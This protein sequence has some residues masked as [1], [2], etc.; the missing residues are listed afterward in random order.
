MDKLNTLIKLSDGN[1]MPRIG[2]GTFQ[3]NYDYTILEQQVEAAVKIAIDLGYRSIDTAALYN[4]EK[5]IGKAV[6][7]KIAEG[8]IKRDEMFITTKLWNTNHRR[9]LVVPALRKSLENLGLDYVDMYLIHWP[10]AVRP[11][12]DPWPRDEQGNVAFEDDVTDYTETWKGMIECKEKG[13]TR[14]IG[15]SNFTEKQIQRVLDLGLERP[16]NMQIEVNPYFL[17]ESLVE[18]C[19]REGIQITCFSP[20]H[21]PSRTWSKPDDPFVATDETLISIGQKFNKSPMQVGLRFLLQ[22]GLAVLPKSNSKEHQ[23]D[24][25]SIFD[26]ELS[27]E[28]MELIKNNCGKFNYRVLR[29]EMLKESKEYPFND[30]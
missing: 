23:R 8:V 25:I 16:V 3:G 27:P 30:S 24:N 12:D 2:L 26:F 17:N 21:K 5:P 11:S 1:L 6:R 4:T 10:C 15:L 9:E 20:L 14:S 7:D 28:D 22:R 19:K 18:F 29:L 13:L